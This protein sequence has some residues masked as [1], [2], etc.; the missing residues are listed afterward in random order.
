MSGEKK[1]SV[2][3]VEETV[4]GKLARNHDG[5]INLY[6]KRKRFVFV[7]N[8]E[9]LRDYLEQ[10]TGMD[11]QYEVAKDCNYFYNFWLVPRKRKLNAKSNKK[12][13]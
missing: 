5:T 4:F 3:R 2:V 6:Q 7:P 8:L 10:K 13:R 12:H 9:K 1:H 11:F